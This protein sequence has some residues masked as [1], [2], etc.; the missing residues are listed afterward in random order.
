[1]LFLRVVICLAPVL[2]FCAGEARAEGGIPISKTGSL[3]YTPIC[4]KLSGAA[5]EQNVGVRK[6]RV[7]FAC[8]CCG[9]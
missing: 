4:A 5:T 7:A 8:R 6:M 9:W 3:A 2:A 1:M